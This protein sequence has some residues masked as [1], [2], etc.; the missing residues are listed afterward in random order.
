MGSAVMGVLSFKKCPPNSKLSREKQGLKHAGQLKSC[1]LG[2][3]KSSKKRI[4][5]MHSISP[6]E[7]RPSLVTSAHNK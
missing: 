1:G 5:T 3:V 7:N 2:S 4:L 6:T